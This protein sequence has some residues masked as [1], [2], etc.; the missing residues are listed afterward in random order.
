MCDS[1]TKLRIWIEPRGMYYIVKLDDTEI[2]I[3]TIIY[4]S[5]AN[6]EHYNFQPRMTNIME[7]ERS[8]RSKENGVLQ[9]YMKSC[10]I[11]KIIFIL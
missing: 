9:E 6:F 1:C 7:I 2:R 4:D 5:K 3:A 11:M 8:K 10:N